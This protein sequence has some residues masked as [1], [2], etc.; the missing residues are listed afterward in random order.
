MI[1][2]PL[3]LGLFPPYSIIL[4]CSAALGLGLIAWMAKERKLFYFDLGLGLLVLSLFGARI[5]YVVRNFLY[6]RSHIGEIP[7]IW[8]GGLTWPG[9]LIGA[10]V[11]L[12][13]IHLIWKEP[14]GDLADL[15]LPL[16]GI[17]TVGIWLTGWGAGIGY[18]PL[19][20]AWFGI[21][22]RD[23]FGIQE[24]RWPL[25]ILGALLSAGW[26]SGLIWFPLR[27]WKIKPG[28]RTALGIVGIVLIN[29]I[30]SFFR[31]DPAPLLWNLRL[32]TW[33]SLALLSIIAGL[34]I[35]KRKLANNEKTGS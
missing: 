18:G 14:L 30:L 20:N 9:A 16:L 19:L 17:I 15:Y 5:G 3:F 21:L 10:G 6:F 32:E 35:R 26:I 25:P 13:G 4:A 28:G 12:L 29:M 33:F 11:A 8:L 7:Q 1:T 22:V 24:I 31:M 2:Q 23:Q 27:R 34:F